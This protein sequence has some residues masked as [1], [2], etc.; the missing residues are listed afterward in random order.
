MESQAQQILMLAQK[1]GGVLDEAGA[2]LATA[3]SCTGGGIACAITEVA[4]SSA[5]FDAGFVTYS[6]A[7]K[8]AMLGVREETL[9]RFGA[10]SEA[11]VLE[12]VAG[13]LERS[14]ASVAVSVSGVAGP[15]GGSEDK[16]VG[17]VW[18]AWQLRGQAG[19]ARLCAFS[20]DRRSV[21]EQAVIAALE[22]VFAQVCR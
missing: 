10:V 2:V 18:I 12:M 4:G 6:N 15:A 22:G 8:R 21:R 19:V 14:V 11:V 20:G 1:L 5:W 3:E 17:T 16:P 7:A 9:Q 13:A